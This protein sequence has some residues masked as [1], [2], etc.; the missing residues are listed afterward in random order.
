MPANP[1]IDSV[2]SRP[3]RISAGAFLVRCLA[4]AAALCAAPLPA[5]ASYPESPASPPAAPAANSSGQQPDIVPFQL[6][7]LAL[8]APLPV[9]PTF[10]SEFT[11][12]YPKERWNGVREA[13]P[14]FLSQRGEY[15]G[16]GYRFVAEMGDVQLRQT[17]N[18]LQEVRRR[19]GRFSLLTGSS[20]SRATFETFAASG[21]HGPGP[22]DTL[23]GA[24]GEL[25]LLD[26]TARFKTIFLSG[27]KSLDKEGRWPTAGAKRGD[28]VGFVA[29][30]EPFKGKLAAEAEYDYSVYD[31]NTADLT[32][33]LHDSACR[34]KL[35]GGIGPSRYTALYERTGPRYRLMSDGPQ[36][37]RQGGSLSV[38]TALAS[39]VLDMKL[40]RY[41]DNVENDPF[42][43]RLYRYEGV[44][45]YRFKGLK[46]LPL[47]L[48]Y[49]KTLIDSSNEPAGYLP[50]ETAEDAVSGQVHYLAGSWDL[51]LRG[52]LSQRSDQLRQQREES[53]TSVGF[54][55]KFS[56]GNFT[57][58][59]D[60]SLKRITDFTVPERTDQYAVNL[61]LT[62]TL[63]EKRLDYELKGG[64]KRESCGLSGGGKEVLGAKVKAAYP[65]VGLFKWSRQPTLG[66][67]GEY[68]GINNLTEDRRENDFSLLISLDGGMFL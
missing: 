10:R 65:L 59:P 30:L 26:D 52:G 20:G 48:Q 68:N 58:T 27:R 11:A 33:A 34:L 67:K 19:G 29:Q 43:P 47:A 51:G 66:I 1:L 4:L 13:Q 16:N 60:L 2:I 37:D 21:G 24:T 40:S 18:T 44:F 35:T 25:S 45:D 28:V 32:S 5:R 14:D 54:M 22:E 15:G 62:G 17:R 49:R 23:V 39:H 7:G 64:F 41:S 53:T 56:A 3:G 55:P 46:A 50:K 38:E 63:M 8:D 61:G 57:V 6:P 42:S 36:R 12:R 9:A 31:G